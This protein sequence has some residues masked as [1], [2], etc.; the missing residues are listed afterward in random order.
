MKSAKP[1]LKTL[2]TAGEIDFTCQLFGA[3][4]LD[5]GY[6]LHFSLTDINLSKTAED[7][8]VNVTLI[9]HTS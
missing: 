2:K 1:C 8:D 9:T 5:F 4:T 7:Q 3:V 6:F